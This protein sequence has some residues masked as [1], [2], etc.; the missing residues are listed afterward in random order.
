MR[1]DRFLILLFAFAIAYFSVLLG[2]VGSGTSGNLKFILYAMLFVCLV[3]GAAFWLISLFES[4]EAQHP[5][6]RSCFALL[7]SMCLCLLFG[8]TAEPF[9]NYGRNPFS[10]FDGWTII[11]LLAMIPLVIEAK[12]IIFGEGRVKRK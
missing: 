12:R 4:F 6:V 11:L 9:K 7:S 5:L 1:L 3:L 2:D 8:F 10:W